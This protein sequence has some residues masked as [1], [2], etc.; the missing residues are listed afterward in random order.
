[1]KTR[2]LPW[3]VL[4]GCT[5]GCERTP[6]DVEKWRNAEGG[7]EKMVEWASSPE[8]SE[9]VRV[10]AVQILV[11]EGQVLRVGPVLESMDEATR[12]KIVAGVMPTVEKMWSAKDWPKVDAEDANKAGMVKVTGKSE[13]V[14]AKDAAYQLYPYANTGDQA[15]IEA[16]LAEWMSQDQDIRNQLGSTTLAQVAPRAGDKGIEMMLAWLDQTD[17]PAIVIDKI[18]AA[19]SGDEPN[20]EINEA[21]AKAVAKRAEAEHPNL[22]QQTRMS[23]LRMNDP[24]IGPYLEKAIT[25]PK[26]PGAQVDEAMV[27][28][29]RAMGERAT[30]F[31]AKLVSEADGNLR[32]V[33]AM[34]LIELR[35]KSGVLA[36]AKAL[37]LEGEIYAEPEPD[38]FKEET[39]KFCRMADNE[40]KKQGVESMEET[41]KSLI[42]S[43]RWPAR[44]IGIRC[45][46][47][48]E[49]GT[50]KADLEAVAGDKQKI[51]GWGDDT[52]IGGFASEVAEGLSG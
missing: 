24:A 43:E 29:T 44:V 20:P 47:M 5:L 42:A 32:W 7:F 17:K 45:A 19:N 22:S 11:E 2:L 14:L 15:K 18:M 38:S 51:P 37:P 50:L 30:P 35:G 49:I 25:D 39:E 9:A 52:T 12:S 4:I 34:R 10:R 3:L 6:A 1:M 33:A 46:Q 23:L 28:Y 27:V 31:Y 21:L 16:I 41:A 13:S 26:T 36:A 40:L 48:N 8:E